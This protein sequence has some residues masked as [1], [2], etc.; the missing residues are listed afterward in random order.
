MGASVIRL[1][2]LVS[3]ASVLQ[4]RVSQKLWLGMLLGIIVF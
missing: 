4:S 1:G 2:P 3:E